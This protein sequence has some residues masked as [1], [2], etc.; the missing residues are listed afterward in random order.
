MREVTHSHVL[1]CRE[2]LSVSRRKP[3]RALRYRLDRGV[4]NFVMALMTRLTPDLRDEKVE[5]QLQKIQKI[6]IVRSL[7]RMGDAIL[8][9]PAIRL[10]RNNFPSA[11]IDFVGPPISER[12][13]ENLPIDRHYAICKTFPRACWSYIGLLKRLRATKYDLAFD[14]SGSSA[15]MGSLIV[16]FSGARLRVGL[17]GRWDRWFNLR[18]DRPS[19][20]NKYDIL[21]NLI[22]SLGLETGKIYPSLFLAGAEINQG[23]AR[24]CDL[25]SSGN[26]PIIGI[27]VGGR[28]ARAK[29]WE[30][31]KFAELAYRLRGSGAQPV[32]FV[33]PEEYDWLG[34]FRREC[35]ET[36]PTVFEPDVRKFAALVYGCHLFVTCDG[37]PM[38]LAC[39]LR[40]RTIAIF[41]TSNVKRWGPPVELG[42]IISG[43]DVCIDKVFEACR[44]E[45]REFSQRTRAAG[46]PAQDADSADGPHPGSS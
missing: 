22:G 38:H 23:K 28:K 10:F 30:K 35:V 45:L 14:A 15:A 8:A 1:F 4:R 26:A 27:F 7:F 29:R 37:G 36:A 41:L 17:S 42:R 20:S 6:L 3:K 39:A 34:Y 32:I 43:D 12:L 19:G 31:E 2:V 46:V 5:L 25:V 44:E 16:G 18:L 13:F 33:G 11:Q 24:V 9:T 40:V 21:P